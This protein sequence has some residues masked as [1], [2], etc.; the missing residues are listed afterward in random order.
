MQ[1]VTE[2]GWLVT[3]SCSHPVGQEDFRQMLAQAARDAH[4]PFR[5]VEW[6]YQSAD[7][8][9]LLAAPE[10]AYLKCAVLRAV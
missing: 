2:D 6:G 7:H 9:V 3:S 8:P 10:T 5:L 1:L 4:R